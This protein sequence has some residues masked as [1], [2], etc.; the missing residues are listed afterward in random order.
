MLLWLC[1]DS[2]G[3]GYYVFLDRFERIGLWLDCLLVM[4]VI[5]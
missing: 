5:V 2:L 1:L 3:G 4:M